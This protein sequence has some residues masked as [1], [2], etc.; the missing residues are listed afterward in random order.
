MQ[1]RC[2]RGELEHVH[3]YVD[4]HVD[5]NVNVNGPAGPR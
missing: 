3:D 4:V 1:E 2:Q 5:V